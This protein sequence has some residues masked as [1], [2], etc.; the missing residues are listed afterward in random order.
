MTRYRRGT[1]EWWEELLAL[2]GGLLAGVVA[3]YV[4]RE[5][6]RREPLGT[7]RPRETE[8]EGPDPDR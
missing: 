7:P 5:L 6:L 1:V 4:G 3:F 8:A 2:G